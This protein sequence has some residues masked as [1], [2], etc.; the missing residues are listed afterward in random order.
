MTRLGH[1][2]DKDTISKYIGHEYHK[3]NIEE[4]TQSISTLDE[5]ISLMG[6]LRT[7]IPEL[8]PQLFSSTNPG[9]VGHQW[10]KDYFVNMAKDKP[11]QD[12]KTGRWRLFIP[13]TIEDNPILMK[14]DPAYYQWLKNLPEP[15]L[16]MWY[17]GS[18]DIFMGQFFPM[19]GTHM[20]VDPWHIGSKAQVRLFGSIDIGIGHNTSF[21]LWYKADDGHIERICSYFANGMYHGFHARAIYEKIESFAHYI[22]G[23]FPLT[24]WIGHDANRR[25]RLG[26]GEIRKP[27]DEYEEV[28]KDKPTRFVVVNPD[29]RHGCALMKQVF[30]GDQ[31]VPVLSY[32]KMFNES[33]ELG[34]QNAQSDPN[35]PE[36]Y[37]KTQKINPELKAKTEKYNINTQSQVEDACDEAMYGIAGIYSDIANEKQLLASKS[38][39]ETVPLTIDDFAHERYGKMMRDSSLA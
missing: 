17:K 20:R 9:G 12:P 24:I 1:W 27:L 2:K 19:F 26:E 28:F 22:D 25:E 7:S 23:N 5:Y 33:F 13:M 35:D 18:W 31:G 29:K 39:R 3:M 36:I 4:L 8:R 10:V 14:N 6:S 32:W 38:Q 15:L 34:I 30:S 16:S 21:G 11:Y 37:L